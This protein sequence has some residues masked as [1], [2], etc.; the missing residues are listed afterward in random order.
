MVSDLAILMMVSYFAKKT[1]VSD[2][3][4]RMMVS[5]LV[6]FFKSFCDGLC[7]RA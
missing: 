6:C 4:F 2:L 1:M 7:P 3:V 5:D